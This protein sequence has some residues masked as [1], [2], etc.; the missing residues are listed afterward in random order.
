M[1][2]SPPQRTIDPS[3]ALLQQARILLDADR[4]AHAV[5]LL[6]Q[7][8]SL[9]P[10]DALLPCHLS[11]T[12]SKLGDLKNALHYAEE[13]IARKPDNEWAHRLRGHVFWTRG[14]HKAAMKCAL[15]AQKVD[16]DE[17]QVYRMQADL[18]MAQRKYKEAKQA[19]E[20]MRS[21]APDQA[22]PFVLLA[23]A[24]LAVVIQSKA[25]NAL[26]GH[27]EAETYARQALA[28]QPDLPAAHNVLGEVLTA[29][30]KTGDALDAFYQASRLDPTAQ[31][32]QRNLNS[33]VFTRF[34]APPML[35][36]ALVLFPAQILFYRW[37]GIWAAGAGGALIANLCATLLMRRFA[38]SIAQK[39]KR[40][41][42][43]PDAQ[44]ETMLGLMRARNSGLVK[45]AAGLA[46]VVS[47]LPALGV[48][49]IS[50]KE[51]HNG[52]GIIRDLDRTLGR[53]PTRPAKIGE[54]R[55]VY[56]W[57]VTVQS[58]EEKRVPPSAKKTGV[59]RFTSDAPWNVAA[60]KPGKKLV[61]V[62]VTIRNED[63]NRF[64]IS[65]A[66]PSYLTDA[67]GNHVSEMLSS[68]TY[69]AK[70]TNFS[71]SEKEVLWDSWN[72]HEQ[73][74]GALYFVVP[75][76]AHPAR[77]VMESPSDAEDRA[78]WKLTP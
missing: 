68:G 43:L 24:T 74:K 42:I 66:F 50:A 65:G 44:R 62:R 64:V 56:P 6:L 15:E 37:G 35:L 12:Y 55:T 17:P 13:G 70:A 20:I 49:W 33:S 11:Y 29:Q 22:A 7:A 21:L 54:T 48:L 32:V 28:I 63:D 73:K 40:F 72:P 27:K 26:A 45:S 3:Q 71:E 75:E 4:P 25:K 9:A 76:N 8:L 2:T 57:K 53:I 47:A 38:P 18:F 30:H 52:R 39:Q 59:F 46:A 10:E 41:R 69:G 23:H 60:Q 36:L 34:F 31:T 5:P 16:P 58:V 77:L 19:A 14:N 61:L 51:P 67:Q 1:E 78:Q